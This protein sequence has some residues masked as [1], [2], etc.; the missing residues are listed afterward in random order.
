MTTNARQI[1]LASIYRRLLERDIFGAQDEVE[2]AMRA[3]EDKNVRYK[4]FIAWTD[5]AL[6]STKHAHEVIRNL[7]YSQLDI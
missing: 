6:G 5:L 1:R 4:L 2:D 3:E 7:H